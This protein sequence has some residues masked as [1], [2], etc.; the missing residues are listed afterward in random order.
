V[1]ARYL[2]SEG[3]EPVVFEQS[4][5]I[6]GQWSGQPE[7]SGVWPSMRTNTSRVMS[8]FSDLP[9]NSE[10]PTYPTNQAMAEYLRQYVEMFDLMHHIRLNTPVRELRRDENGAWLLRTDAGEERFDRV[11]VASGRYHKP[12]IAD[13]PGAETFSGSMGVSHTFGYQHPEAFR[14]LR[15]LVTGCSISSLEI[16]SDLATNG[17]SRVVTCNRNQRYVLPKLVAGVPLE[18]L[19]FTR[20]GALAGECFPMEAVGTAM[21][22]FALGAAGSPDQFGAPRPPDNIF[23]AGITQSQFYLPLV[24]EGRIAVKPWIERIDGQTV[25]FADGSSEDFD[26]IVFGTG[27]DLHLP[28]LSQDLQHTLDLDSKHIDLYKFTFHPD[29]P[30]L[31]FLGL[32][33]MAGPYYPVLELQ[34]RWIAYTFS[35]A[36]P[37]PQKN[38][39]EAGVA[40]FRARRGGPQ[41]M[42]MH[43]AALLFA[44][45]AGVEPEFDRW[46][47]LARAFF[48]GPLAPVS[49][50]ISG[51][52]S[53][54]N[55]PQRFTSDAAAFGCLPCNDLTPMQTGQLKALAE[56]RGDA[57][58]SRFVETVA[59]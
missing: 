35:G 34:A 17:A 49:F 21:K 19:A 28:F 50:R 15:V 40:A 53:L 25:H 2:R 45:A 26:G 13:V 1:A 9:H 38:E 59:S 41:T 54:A 58:F 23:E 36:I 57:A 33:E 14:G 42:P 52:D 6:G 51:K 39:L 8:S 56:A 3:F 46:P 27:Y 47:E 55:A 11:V 31:A 12:M 30:G 4:G 7:H 44:R 32:F 48:F 16:A 22:D 43:A 24:A 18:H 37:S 10:S 5:R 20:F 29:L